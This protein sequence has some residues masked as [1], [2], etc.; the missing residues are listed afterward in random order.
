MKK[1]PVKGREASPI[2]VV[3]GKGLALLP[4]CRLKEKRQ[5]GCLQISL[6]L[7]LQIIYNNF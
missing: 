2:E 7:H 6:A 3:C 5:K 4:L 1:K